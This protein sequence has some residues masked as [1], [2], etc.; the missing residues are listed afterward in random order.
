MLEER[1]NHLA[2]GPLLRG[3]RAAPGFVEVLHEARRGR[4]DRLGDRCESEELVGHTERRDELCPDAS[5][6]TGIMCH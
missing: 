6:S 1:V 2:H 3:A 4:T 5:A